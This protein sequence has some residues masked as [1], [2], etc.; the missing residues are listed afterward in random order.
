M[1]TARLPV[2]P[3]RMGSS[4]PFRFSASIRSLVCPSNSSRGW[5]RSLSVSMSFRTN[6]P[7]LCTPS[8]LANPAFLPISVMSASRALEAPKLC[9]CVS[10]DML[11]HLSRLALG[12]A[13]VGVHRIQELRSRTCERPRADRDVQHFEHLRV[14]VAGERLERPCQVIL[15]RLTWERRQRPAHLLNERLHTFRA[16]TTNGGRLDLI[17]RDF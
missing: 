1:R 4:A 13:A 15:I 6:D 7:P 5:K 3:T 2:H 12:N 9:S 11:H 8:G 10:S 16:W 14:L 17:H